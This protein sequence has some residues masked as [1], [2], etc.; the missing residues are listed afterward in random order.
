M[1]FEEMD[2]N[3]DNKTEISREDRDEALELVADT[4]V[5]LKRLEEKDGDYSYADTADSLERLDSILESNSDYKNSLE[6]RKDASQKI[7]QG[8]EDDKEEGLSQIKSW[9]EEVRNI[10]N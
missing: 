9:L 5:V 7:I 1:S 2:T 8:N 6:V 4:E 10:L 3:Q